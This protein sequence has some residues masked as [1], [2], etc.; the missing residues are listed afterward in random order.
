MLNEMKLQAY[1]KINLSLDVLRKRPDGY[2]DVR[3]VMQTVKLHDNIDLT[4]RMSRGSASR[5]IFLFF[6]WMRTI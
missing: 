5:R 2:H 1:G 4:G 3:M 6:R